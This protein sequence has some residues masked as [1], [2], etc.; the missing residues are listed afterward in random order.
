MCSVKCAVCRVQC[1]GQWCK[2][3]NCRCDRYEKNDFPKA[4]PAAGDTNRSLESEDLLSVSF[5]VIFW[6]ESNTDTFNW[7]FVCIRGEISTRPF[8][9]SEYLYYKICNIN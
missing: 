5:Q 3:V 6:T 1:V 4:N 9:K 7:G 2:G 8:V